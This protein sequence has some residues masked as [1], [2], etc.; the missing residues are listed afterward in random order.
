MTEEKRWTTPRLT[1]LAHG[2]PEESV[3]GVCKHSTHPVH[4][5]PHVEHQ[6]CEGYLEWPCVLCSLLGES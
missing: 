6:R 5:V 3:L 4:Q 2:S 1:V